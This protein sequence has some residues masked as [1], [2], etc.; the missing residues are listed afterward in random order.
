MGC[1]VEA[2]ILP[3]RFVE[4]EVECI[5]DDGDLGSW[6]EKGDEVAESI[7]HLIGGEVE[8]HSASEI[9]EYSAPIVLAKPSMRSGDPSPQGMDPTESPGRQVAVDEKSVVRDVAFV[10]KVRTRVQGMG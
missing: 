3:A 2:T 8:L 4:D 7:A 9:A 10:G 1:C 6:P 5:G